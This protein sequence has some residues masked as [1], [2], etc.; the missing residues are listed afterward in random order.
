M[1]SQRSHPHAF[2][3]PHQVAPAASAFLPTAGSTDVDP[4]GLSQPEQDRPMPAYFH[5]ASDPSSSSSSSSSSFSLAPPPS[6]SPFSSIPALP[7]VADSADGSSR[8]TY[9]TRHLQ[10]NE[11]SFLRIAAHVTAQKD[12]TIKALQDALELVQKQMQKMEKKFDDLASQLSASSAIVSKK[13]GLRRPEPPDVVV[14]DNHLPLPPPSPVAG[15][16][17]AP[18]TTTVATEQKKK[19]DEVEERKKNE[20]VERARKAEEDKKRVEEEA[21]RKRKADEEEAEMKR[22][23]E[24]EAEEKRKREEAIIRL[25]EI[26]DRKRKRQEEDD[27]DRERKRRQRQ[28]E[29]DEERDK[30]RKKRE[31]EEQDELE[32]ERLRQDCGGVLPPSSSSS[33]SANAEAQLLE[34]Q[35]TASFVD[36]SALL[37]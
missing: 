20:E 9:F 22:K 5:Q 19:R 31:Q 16:V 30:Q 10:A 23:A 26:S 37:S 36:V 4:F 17:S 11:A 3:A 32:E 12:A 14:H 7:V 6:P 34:A 15:P 8:A 33:S 35:M 1:P 2:Y 28:L 18:S 13:K 24:E 21:E 27:Q 29:E 25:K